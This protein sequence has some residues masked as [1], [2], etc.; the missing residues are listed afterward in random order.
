MMR[1]IG[2]GVLTILAAIA[3]AQSPPESSRG[4]LLYTTHCVACHTTEVHWREK[5]LVS[6]WASLNAQVERW[7]KNAKLGWSGEDV[8][9]VARHLNG[10]YYHLPAPAGKPVGGR[11]RPFQIALLD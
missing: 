8:D 10:A 9:A 1:A 5:K 4:D 3:Q 7:Q 2:C 6:D 11:H